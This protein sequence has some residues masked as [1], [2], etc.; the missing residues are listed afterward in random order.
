[1]ATANSTSDEHLS[2][3]SLHNEPAYPAG[4]CDCGHQLRVERRYAAWVLRLT[5]NYF[6]R[7]GVRFRSWKWRLLRA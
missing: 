1:M 7:L 4:C 6:L 5:A 3:C 2:D